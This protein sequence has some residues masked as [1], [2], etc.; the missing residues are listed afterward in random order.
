L[1]DDPQLIIDL[2]TPEAD[3]QEKT[4]QIKLE[5]KKDMKKRGAD[6]PDKGD[7]LALTFYHKVPSKSQFANESSYEPEVI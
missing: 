4:Q 5:S 3:Y 6:S 7:A 2:T 1:P